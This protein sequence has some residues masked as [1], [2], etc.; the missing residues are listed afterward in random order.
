MPAASP[1]RQTIFITSPLEA[2]HA[3]RIRET[4][5]ARA[6]LIFDPD[7][8]APL[9]YQGDHKGRDGFTLT[10]EQEARR[11]AHLGRATILWDF[12]A[13]KPEH[14]GGLARAPNVR[15]VQTTSAGVGQLVHSLG[16]AN[17]DLLVTTARGVHAE[18]LA[19]FVFLAFLAHAKDLPRLQTDQ[20]AHRWERYCCGELAGKTVLIIGA[21]SIGS[22]VGRIAAAF[23]MRVIAVVNQPSPARKAELSA[24]E[25]VGQDRLLEMLPRADYV[26]MCTPHTPRTE[27]M[28]SAAAIAAMKPGVVFVNIG[29]GQLVDEP[30]MIAALRSKHIAFAALDVALVEPLPADSPLWDL[31]NVLISPHSAS[32]APSE[33]GKITEIFCRNLACYLD[34][35]V[36]EMINVLDKQRMY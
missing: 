18:A 9:R 31:P 14:G 3:A 13:G 12:P 5:G 27:G 16:L 29:R 20:R 6:E 35:R 19:E 24:D 8:F 11:L 7:L 34:G 26:V 36:G 10:A 1:T 17:S 21:G 28:I 32:T 25:V 15:W 4:A 23:G 2:E 22:Q 33:N 30:A